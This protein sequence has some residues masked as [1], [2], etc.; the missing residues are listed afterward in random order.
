MTLDLVVGVPSASCCLMIAAKSLASVVALGCR[1]RGGLFFASLFSALVGHAFAYGLNNAAG[2][3]SSIRGAALVGM[4]AL[5]VT[6]VGGPLTMAMLVLESDEQ[7]LRADRR[8][9]CR[10]AGRVADR[11]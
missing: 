1:F 10:I 8:G 2:S 11:P 4:A 7:R 3:S 9:A 6:V 5:A